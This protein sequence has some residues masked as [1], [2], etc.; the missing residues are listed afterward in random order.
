MGKKVNLFVS[1]FV[2]FTLLLVT[3]FFVS[4]VKADGLDPTPTPEAT[5]DPNLYP[6]PTFKLDDY[7]DGDYYNPLPNVIPWMTY[8][9]M[10]DEPNLSLYKAEDG[11]RL[12]NPPNSARLQFKMYKYI[13]DPIYSPPRRY[14]YANSDQLYA[15]APAWGSNWFYDSNYAV[16]SKFDPQYT[17]FQLSPNRQIYY[18]SA[19]SAYLSGQNY[20]DGKDVRYWI[21]IPDFSVQFAESS[22]VP[23]VNYLLTI[24][25]AFDDNTTN[26]IGAAVTG[27]ELA[28]GVYLDAHADGKT[29]TMSIFNCII[30]CEGVDFSF[31]TSG[32]G[33]GTKAPVDPPDYGGE[34]LLSSSSGVRINEFLIEPKYTNTWSSIFSLVSRIFVPSSV[35]FQSWI[36]TQYNDLSADTYAGG[37][38][39]GKYVYTHFLS[40]IGSAGRPDTPVLHIPPLNIGVDGARYEYFHGYDFDFSTVPDN[41]W[42]YSRM[43][44]D[45]VLVSGFVS[46]LWTWF[47]RWYNTHFAKQKNGD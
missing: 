30:Y 46:L 32:S 3:F 43:V 4:D 29:V 22:Y 19:R 21:Q 1:V 2:I 35:D 27:I 9:N 28:N 41:I 40:L 38:G 36:A 45:I 20:N 11:G 12:R 42:T 10:V 6:I 47:S 5:L 7:E 44:G 13:Y 24:T 37:L 8:I 16:L 33:S 18:I 39:Y 31:D 25:L 34:V 23:A 14:V 15:S 17:R 26:T